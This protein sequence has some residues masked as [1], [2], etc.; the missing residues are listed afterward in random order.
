MEVD[1]VGRVGRLRLCP[2]QYHGDD[3]ALVGDLF[4][5]DGEPLGNVLLLGHESGRGRMRARELALEVTRRVDTDDP[6]RLAGVGD[7]DALDASVR[8]R[9]AYERG[10]RGALACEV[11]DVV[12]VTSDEP[13]I[14]AA[15][16]LGSD[17]LGDRHVS[18]PPPRPGAF[19]PAS[20]SW[21]WRRFAQPWRC[22]RI[23]YTGTG[24]LPAP[25]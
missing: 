2:R 5:G 10:R 21:S 3:L 11:V 16:D 22:S 7:V 25:S 18:S 13:R 24:C 9:A 20:R 6:G 14:F 23:P 19:G 1:Y 4:L 15:M 17:D 8:D 12:A